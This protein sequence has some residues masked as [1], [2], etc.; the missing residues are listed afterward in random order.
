MCITGMDKLGGCIREGALL[1]GLKSIGGREGGWLPAERA[2]IDVLR[3]VAETL[4]DGD[5]EACLWAAAAAADNDAA[6]GTVPAA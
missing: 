4:L 5:P 1:Q 2:C 6:V 3:A